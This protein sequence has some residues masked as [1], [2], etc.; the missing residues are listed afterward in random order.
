MS[1]DGDGWSEFGETEN[2]RIGET[3]RAETEKRGV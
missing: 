3:G 1:S 2:R